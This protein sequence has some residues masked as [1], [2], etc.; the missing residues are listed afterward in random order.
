MCCSCMAEN[1]VIVGK[2]GSQRTPSKTLYTFLVVHGCWSN[3]KGKTVD[4][5][6]RVLALDPLLYCLIGCH[7]FQMPSAHR[8]GA[9]AA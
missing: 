1:L 6:Q 9:F 2:L 4:A 5:H 7:V 8:P 3:M